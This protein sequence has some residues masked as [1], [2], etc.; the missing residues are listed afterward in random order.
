MRFP[1]M[2]STA[3]VDVVGDQTLHHWAVSRLRELEQR[4]SRFVPDSDVAQLN[5]AA[6]RPCVVSDDTCTLVEIACV[7]WRLTD[8][9]FDP[10]VYDSMIA[11]GY[12]RTWQDLAGTHLVRTDGLSPAPGCGAIVVDREARL[13]WLPRNVR[14]DPGGLGKGLA[15]DLVAEELVA[16]G[17]QAA[18]VEIGGDLRVAGRTNVPWKIGMEHP[19]WPG[20]VIGTCRLDEGGIAS[21][22][23]LKRHWQL[24]DRDQHHLVDPVTGHNPTT[25]LDTVTVVAGTA[26]WAEALT[27]ALF[28][29][30]PSEWSTVLQGNTAL[31]VDADGR[32]TTSGNRRLMRVALRDSDVTSV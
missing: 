2:G 27:K 4:W 22:S 24:N 20:K 14:L 19:H 6:G 32:V 3:H 11:S 5:A 31:G 21:S 1:L 29:T 25:T 12:D 23:R 26:W 10:T 9:K 30:P 18:L 15:A 7:A 28:L 16:R 13:V 8:G 17:A